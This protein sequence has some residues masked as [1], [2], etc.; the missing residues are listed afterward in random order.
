MKLTSDSRA[1]AAADALY[2][3]RLGQHGR[4]RRARRR[5]KDLAPVPARRR[6]HGRGQDSAR[7]SLHC[8]PRAPRRR[9]HRRDVLYGG[10]SRRSS[11][12][13]RTGCTRRRRC[14]S[15]C[16]GEGAGSGTGCCPGR[17]AV[18]VGPG[19]LIAVVPGCDRVHWGN[20]RGPPRN[21][22]MNH[23]ARGSVAFFPWGFSKKVHRSTFNWDPVSRLEFER[24]LGREPARVPLLDCPHGNSKR[25]SGCPGRTEASPFG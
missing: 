14:W 19:R 9:D 21:E 25:T 12:R 7:S 3:G 20:P 4:R 10:R 24:S 13:P 1:A 23:P 17:P 16:W 6:P 22:S 18:E 15:F 2:T 8:L 5:R 11:T